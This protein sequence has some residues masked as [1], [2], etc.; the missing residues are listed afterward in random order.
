MPN[1]VDFSI[2]E[3]VKIAEVHPSGWISPLFV[4]YG[5][6]VFGGQ[7]SYFWRVKGTQHTFVIPV[8][9]IDFLSQGDYA[10]HFEKILENFRDDYISWKEDNFSQ[11]WMSEY[12]E[13]F[14]AFIS[15]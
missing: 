2:I 3:N 11:Q 8:I 4:E 6:S 7:P 14:A 15:T 5:L 13:Q 10:T 12:R 1:N 9:R